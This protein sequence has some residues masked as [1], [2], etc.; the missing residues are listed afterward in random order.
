MAKWP[1]YTMPDRFYNGETDD[2]DSGIQPAN[3]ADQDDWPEI[4]SGFIPRKFEGKRGWEQ[5]ENHKGEQ[6]Y[7]NGQAHTITEYGPYPDGWSATPP[8]PT[9]EEQIQT[10]MA[11][12]EN[13]IQARLDAFASTLTYDGMLSA[14]TYATSSVDMYRIEG[15]YCVDARDATWAKAYELL[16]AILPTVTAGGAI[17]MWENIESELPPLAW[18]EGSRG[19]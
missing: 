5:V 12:F 9:Q 6:G 17:P 16:A 14:C 2:H 3:T 10:A 15:Q 13:R 19:A 4:K 18:P 7:V 11:D 1:Q 8:E